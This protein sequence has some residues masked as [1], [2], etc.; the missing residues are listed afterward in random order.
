M[1]KTP[2]SKKSSSNNV[3]TPNNNGKPSTTT[4]NHATISKKITFKDRLFQHIEKSFT[5]QPQLTQTLITELQQLLTLPSVTKEEILHFFLSLFDQCAEQ[6]HSKNPRNNFADSTFF[7]SLSITLLGSVV[8]SSIQQNVNLF[9]LDEL[10]K[11]LKQTQQQSSSGDFYEQVKV[12]LV[13]I[14]GCFFTGSVFMGQTQNGK[15]QKSNTLL[16]KFVEEV[17]QD[18]R[19]LLKKKKEQGENVEEKKQQAILSVLFAEAIGAILTC[20]KQ[21][22]LKKNSSVTK[23]ELDT[24]CMELET[25]FLPEIVDRTPSLPESDDDDEEMQE[26]EK[27]K[28]LK[29][30]E[31][32]MDGPFSR[33]MLQSTYTELSLYLLHYYIQENSPSTMVERNTILTGGRF[34]SEDESSQFSVLLTRSF[35]ASLIEHMNEYRHLPIHCFTTHFLKQLIEPIILTHLKKKS[36]KTSNVEDQFE[37]AKELLESFFIQLISQMQAPPSLLQQPKTG[38]T[39][40]IIAQISSRKAYWWE[41]QV[42]QSVLESLD[43]GSDKTVMNFILDNILPLG[44]IEGVVNPFLVMWGAV[45]NECKQFLKNVPTSGS[46]SPT[47][48]NTLLNSLLMLVVKKQEQKKRKR[49]AEAEE[50]NTVPNVETE[51][52]KNEYKMKQVREEFFQYQI[53]LGTQLRPRI[54]S[55]TSL[56]PSLSKYLLSR[57][58][59]L[60]KVS[61][62]LGTYTAEKLS[63]FTIEAD[64]KKRKA[65]EDDED[66]ISLSRR[67]SRSLLRGLSSWLRDSIKHR[68]GTITRSILLILSQYDEQME[69]FIAKKNQMDLVHDTLLQTEE[70]EEEWLNEEALRFLLSCFPTNVRV[71]DK[72]EDSF[73]TEDLTILLKKLFEVGSLMNYVSDKPLLTKKSDEERETLIRHRSYYG[74]DIVDL[75]SNLVKLIINNLAVQEFNWMRQQ[76]H[77]KEVKETEKQLTSSKSWSNELYSYAIK[78]F[79]LEEKSKQEKRKRIFETKDNNSNFKKLQSLLGSIQSDLDKCSIGSSSKACMDWSI[80]SSLAIYIRQVLVTSF[81]DPWIIES[82]AQGQPMVEDLA[83]VYGTISKLSSSDLILICQ[84]K[85]DSMQDESIQPME[86]LTDVLVVNIN[87]EPNLT[88][89]SRIVFMTIAK[90]LNE[91]CLDILFNYLMKDGEVQDIEDES[92]EEE[93]EEEDDES[94]DEKTD[95]LDEEPLENETEGSV[96]IRTDEE[97]EEGGIDL[98]NPGDVSKVLEMLKARNEAKKKKSEEKQQKLKRMEFAM[99]IVQV[100]EGLCIKSIPQP[101]L[102]LLLFK[103]TQYI[104]EKIWSQ[105]DEEVAEHLKKATGYAVNTIF[106]KVLQLVQ[107]L[108]REYRQQLLTDSNS[109]ICAIVF[110]QEAKDALFETARVF[111]LEFSKYGILLSSLQGKTKKSITNKNSP[112]LNMEQ[113]AHMLSIFIRLMYVLKKSD[114]TEMDS[115]IEKMLFGSSDN[116][117]EMGTSMELL[118]SLAQSDSHIAST[119]GSKIIMFALDKVINSGDKKYRDRKSGRVLAQ[120]PYQREMYDRILGSLVKPF[121]L[122][123]SGENKTSST[124]NAVLLMVLESYVKDICPAMKLIKSTSIKA[125]NLKKSAS[126]LLTVLEYL[127][128]HSSMQKDFT[129]V[130]FRELLTCFYFVFH[131]QEK[132]QGEEKKESI[133]TQALPLFEEWRKRWNLGSTLVQDFITSNQDLDKS[134]IEIMKQRREVFKK[135]RKERVKQSTEQTPEE[136]KKKRKRNEKKELNEPVIEKKEEVKKEKPI[137]EAPQK[138]R[139]QTPSAFVFETDEK[140][141]QTIEEMKKKSGDIPASKKA[142][143]TSVNQTDKKSSNK[144]ESTLFNETASSIAKK[145]TKKPT[146][147]ATQKKSKQ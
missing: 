138:K 21:A 70:K 97:E 144:Q 39:S 110:E 133:W 106:N 59:V 5:Q 34:S 88:L 129:E 73:T 120:Q 83:R 56:T 127:A 130:Q 60:C 117:E 28:T 41:I 111:A 114:N 84:K 47:T 13:F 145:N 146:K 135:E 124:A 104:L 118:I 38:S 30:R 23:K 43:K 45:L 44:D 35:M 22:S 29:D 125:K 134:A 89:A 15:K 26:G 71:Y 91:E 79:G 33:N 82:E 4:G 105:N 57:E 147:T 42:F 96:I 64:K 139:K 3:A 119:L 53:W 90:Y 136:N 32:V 48:G 140:P 65:Q 126:V 86:V 116:D 54:M 68:V 122:S 143:A 69:R 37:L 74:K 101:V 46:S 36:K 20:M 72:S 1:P 95:T 12:R 75:S 107:I 50:N 67:T 112:S 87:V 93:E 121:V 7:S 61:N 25:S 142:T 49:I 10:Y 103:S 141:V 81:F 55:L 102:I 17:Q 8:P 137:E 66:I 92:D 132:K 128:N 16:S 94:D 19:R 9:S 40:D 51:A 6:T 123:L 80:L 78:L 109:S 113:S 98:N 85:E 63:T 115:Q 18:Y 24:L 27:K 76:F 2:T 100:L 131:Q 62:T 31:V 77:T 52:L 99:N 11:L 14:T 108:T 58:S